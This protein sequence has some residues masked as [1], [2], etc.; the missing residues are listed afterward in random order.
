MDGRDAIA[1]WQTAIASHTDFASMN[2]S[3]GNWS[4][5]SSCIRAS[6]AGV[7]FF[8]LKISV[9]VAFNRIASPAKSSMLCSSAANVDLTTCVC[10]RENQSKT[11][12]SHGLSIGKSVLAETSM[13]IAPLIANPSCSCALKA[14]SDT[15]TRRKGPVNA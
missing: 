9:H 8:G 11:M 14:E 10:R 13:M 12:H 2:K 6:V 15:L 7:N 3:I 4:C 1:G 5:P